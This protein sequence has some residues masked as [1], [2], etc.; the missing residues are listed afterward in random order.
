MD[1]TANYL[2]TLG[3]CSCLDFSHLLTLFVIYIIFCFCGNMYLVYAVNILF[4]VRLHYL[5]SCSDI[6][7]Y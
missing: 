2:E 1:T 3:A 5:V 4:T 7:E 6:Q